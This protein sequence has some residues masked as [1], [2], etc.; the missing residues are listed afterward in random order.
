[1]SEQPP[2]PG[3]AENPA[4]HWLV[5]AARGPAA[6]LLRLP[7]SKSIT[8]RALVLAA[9]SAGPS[10]IGGPL[11]SRDT[12]LM[13]R[14]L[15]ALGC[16]IDGPP[17]EGSPAGGGD[18]EQDQ[19]QLT[20]RAEP[21][22]PAGATVTVDAGNAGTV[23]RFVPPVAALGSAEVTFTGDER[24]TARP[25]GQ[26]LS[27]L[28]GLGARIADEGRGA[29][30]FVVL[31]GGNVPGGCVTI[32]ASA[33]SQLV[34]GLLLAGPRFDRGVEVRHE[35]PPV[36][37][38][39]HIEMTIAM[40]AA[41]GAD[42]SADA[43]GSGRAPDRW[44]V[45][46]SA[47]SLGHV[48]V[49]PDLSNAL[50]FLAAALVTGGEVTIAGWPARSLQA[51]DRILDLLAQLGAE[52]R[53]VPDGL[54]VAGTGAIQGIRA[55]LSEVGELTP[56]LTALAALAG[57]PSELTGIGHLRGHETD[58]LAALALEI[59]KLGGEVAER[60]DGLRVVPKP[61]RGEGVVFDSHDDHR[62]VMAAAVL[63]LAVPGIT[64]SDAGTVGKTFPGFT[65]FWTRSLGL[66]P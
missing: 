66:A 33:S 31:G 37:S 9:L 22:R 24:I 58:R 42:V 60:P 41:A 21:R 11:I 64:V 27:A 12:M 40:L 56:V 45:R 10:V 17:P 32:D 35:G 62:L 36:P 18:G 16:R 38:A 30:P 65:R 49:E 13:V 2:A 54:T 28:R 55:N 8:N 34:S 50:P 59:G 5:P 29:A 57:S 3:A 44:R 43:S 23:L 63:G 6:G 20:W 46:P 7:G 47:I 19:G 48:W 15:R 39:P 1:M 25:V 14:A 61:L 51:A 53:H 52:V 26:L 4:G